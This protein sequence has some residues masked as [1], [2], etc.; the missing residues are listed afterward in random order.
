[1]CVVEILNDV[2]ASI[3]CI[4]IFS[5]QLRVKEL[6]SE[7][8]RAEVTIY[9]LEQDGRGRRE[10]KEEKRGRSKSPVFDLHHSLTI[11][12]PQ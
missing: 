8:R 3:S 6:E 2:D 4:E 1:M 7:L 5:L 11:R 12:V 9:N 10:H